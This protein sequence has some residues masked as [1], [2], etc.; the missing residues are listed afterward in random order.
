MEGLIPLERTHLT[1]PNSDRMQAPFLFVCL[2]G[3]VTLCCLAW[4]WSWSNSRY[5]D[6]RFA[7]PCPAASFAFF[8]CPEPLGG[9]IFSKK[10]TSSGERLHERMIGLSE[11]VA[12]LGQFWADPGASECLNDHVQ[13]HMEVC[14]WRPF[15]FHLWLPSPLALSSLSSLLLLFEQCPIVSPLYLRVN[16]SYLVSSCRDG[17]NSPL[18][19]QNSNLQRNRKLGAGEGVPWVGAQ[20]WRDCLQFGNGRT[21]A[22]TPMFVGEGKATFKMNHC[23]A[24]VTHQILR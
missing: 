12:Y 19:E 18:K 1:Y 23:P 17:S 9:L 7:A 11:A 8:C 24:L 16:L 6:Y 2:G 22:A 10:I 20:G 3:C 21:E 15:P 5:W 14:P 13:F 4:L